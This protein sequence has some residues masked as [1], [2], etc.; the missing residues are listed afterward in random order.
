M[1]VKALV[2]T[3]IKST[4]S[5]MKRIKVPREKLVVEEQPSPASSFLNWKKSFTPR[6]T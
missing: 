1:T 4:E 2:F 5:K 6:N 3:R